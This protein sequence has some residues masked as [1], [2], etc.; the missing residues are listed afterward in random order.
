MRIGTG[1]IKWALLGLLAVGLWPPAHSFLFINEA[2]NATVARQVLLGA[3]LYAEAADWK[4]P[5]GYLVYAALLG[6]TGYSLVALHLAALGLAVWLALGAA[7]LARRLGGAEAAFPAAA[8]ALLFLAHT[9]GPPLEMD[10]I[11]AGLAAGGYLAFVSF[12]SGGPRASRLLP[13]LSGL[14]LVLAVGVKQV[15]GLDGLVLLGACL[16][17]RRSAE[18][19]PPARRALAP[20]LL[21]GLAGVALTALAVVRYSTLRD[22]LA[23]AC[24]I[25][26]AGQ[27]VSLAQRLDTW[28]TLFSLMVAP[29]GLLVGLG[30]AGAV[31]VGRRGVEGL[32]PWWLAAG[33]LGVLV[34]SQAL[35]YHLTQIAAPLAVLGALGLTRVGGTLPPAGRRYLRLV[36]GIGL[37]LGL[38][39]PARE[40]AWRWRDR[41]LTPPGT[42]VG[43][44][45]GAE[46]ARATGPED[47]LLVMSHDPSVL[48]WSGRRAASRYLMREHYWNRTL[49][50]NLPRLSRWLGPRADPMKL[51]REEVQGT[52]PRF[53]LVPEEEPLFQE[54]VSEGNRRAWLRELLQGYRL[55]GRNPLYFVYER[56][57]E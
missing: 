23:W 31:I 55:A 29:V 52:R 9:L 12:L 3:R 50:V 34:G 26:W 39:A 47:R 36:V 22:Y 15:V 56:E 54:E 37:A 14:L 25:P 51:L 42:E 43:R 49:E 1:G 19:G 20:L 38:M 28:L 46:L 4:G 24:L 33:G 11:M 35:A 5:L 8:F 18:Y 41:V 40:A 21:G 57:E 48:F 44:L 10:L 2:I 16:W 13:A 7:Q 17:W 27:Q 45:V 30:I 53:I 32:L 6:P